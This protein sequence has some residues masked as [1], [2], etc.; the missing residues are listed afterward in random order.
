MASAPLVLLNGPPGIGKSTLAPLLVAQRP[1]S[2]C[3]DID[4]LR[5]SL[6][7]WAEHPQRSGLLARDLA[8]AAARTHLASGHVVV[9]PQFLGQLAF[10]QRLEALASEIG[11]PFRHVVLM[12]D[13]EHAIERF[14]A[15]SRAAGAPEQHREAAAMAGGTAGLT[16]MYDALLRILTE[17]PAAIVIESINGDVPA[18][19]RQLQAALA[20]V[21]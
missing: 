20:D 13:Q 10:I 2:L 15:R 6:V 16:T 1:L 5:R 4:L 11:S 19:L 7:H 17:R 21:L 14:M 12:D 8:V 18:T 9:V 3:L